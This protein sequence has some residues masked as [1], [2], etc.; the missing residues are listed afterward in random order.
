MSLK[1]YYDK[2]KMLKKEWMASEILNMMEK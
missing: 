1:G 2:K